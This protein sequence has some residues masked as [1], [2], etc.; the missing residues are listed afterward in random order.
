MINNLGEYF[1]TRVL[2]TDLEMDLYPTL[3]KGIIN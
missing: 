1:K 2:S 3:Y